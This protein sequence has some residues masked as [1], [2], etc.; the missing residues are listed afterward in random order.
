MSIHT[1]ISDNL[2]VRSVS[3]WSQPPVSAIVKRFNISV[4]LPFTI[5]HKEMTDIPRRNSTDAFVIELTLLEY[6]PSGD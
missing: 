6:V 3:T 1:C 5:R 2:F 4:S